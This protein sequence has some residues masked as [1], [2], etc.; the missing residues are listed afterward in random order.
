MGETTTQYINLFDKMLL[1]EAGCLFGVK[2]KT[3]TY[4]LDIANI[5]DTKLVCIIALC[6]I[7]FVVFIFSL[8]YK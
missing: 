7:S 8:Y 5:I 1:I 3:Q 6:N 2:L 4:F